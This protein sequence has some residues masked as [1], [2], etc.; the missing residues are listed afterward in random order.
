MP[1]AVDQQFV[2]SIGISSR[3]LSDGPEKELVDWFISE[4]PLTTPVGCR[5]TIFREPRL[6]SGFPDIVVVCWHPDVTRRWRSDRTQL[7]NRD[8]RV[9]HF[10]ASRRSTT[11]D[12]MSSIFAGDLSSSLL[13]LEAAGTIRSTGGQ[14][15]PRPLSRIFAVECIIA[16]EAKVRGWN[17][18]LAQ[19]SLNTWFA[20]QSFVLLP[21][22]P[23]LEGFVDAAHRRGV[24]VWTRNDGCVSK[25]KQRSGILPLSYASWLFNEWVWRI[26]RFTADLRPCLSM[27]TGSENSFQTSTT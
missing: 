19:A 6:E 21:D 17:H 4:F 26:D 11:L 14:F 9:M 2:A 24:G 13:R 8:I 27:S 22:S 7:T 3:R 16:F 18:V 25:P 12:E 1:V 20:S 15:V 10:V 23:R 5:T